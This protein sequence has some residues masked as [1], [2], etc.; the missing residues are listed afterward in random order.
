M[1]PMLDAVKHLLGPDNIFNHCTSLPLAEEES[2]HDAKLPC[3]VAIGRR[4]N[5]GI[6]KLVNP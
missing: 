6:E 4:G 2:C 3:F 1:A 5:D